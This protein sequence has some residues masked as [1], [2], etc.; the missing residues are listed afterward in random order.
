MI[1]LRPNISMIPL[2]VNGQ[3]TAIKR[4]QQ[5]ECKKHDPTICY[6]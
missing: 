5:G 1:D 3:N 6:P 2:K 4:D